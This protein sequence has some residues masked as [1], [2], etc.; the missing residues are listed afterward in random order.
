MNVRNILVPVDFSDASK[1]AL[2]YGVA[3]AGEFE[4]K[5]VVVHIVEY[6]RPLA[7]AFPTETFATEKH[8]FGEVRAKLST[9][10]PKEVRDEMDYRFVVKLGEPEDEVLA[11]VSDEKA[12]LVVMGSH[13]RRAF[14]RWILGSVTEHLLRRLP[15]PVMTVSH[16]GERLVPDSLTEGRILYAT[17]LSRGSGTGLETA[18]D[19]ARH[20][21]ADLTVLNVMLPLQLEYGK[22]YLPLDIGKDHDALHKD[23]SEQLA[24]SVPPSIQLDEHVRLETGEGVPYEVILNRA[25]QLSADLVVINLHGK[26]R[27]ERTLIGSTAERVVRASS[28][29][30]LSIPILDSPDT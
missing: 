27:Q 5:L 6:S 3:L 17:D 9:L 26:S 4:S 12:D 21:A 11:S 20:F 2:D 22:S 25:G 8:E 1:K 19:W 23:L 7:Y 18:W 30:V 13:G 28:R 15:V 14:R 24:N 29:P 10:I 16:V